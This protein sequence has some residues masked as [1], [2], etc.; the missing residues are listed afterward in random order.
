MDSVKEVDQQPVESPTADPLPRKE[1]LQDAM[2]R[3]QNLGPRL[4]CR[5]DT[6]AESKR[7]H[8]ELPHSGALEVGD[9]SRVLGPPFRAE[10]IYLGLH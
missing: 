3:L 6:A 2:E 4:A 10:G 7:Q 1:G 9:A 8:G 5:D